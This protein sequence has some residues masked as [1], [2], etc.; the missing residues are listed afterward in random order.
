MSIYIST[1]NEDFVAMT[2]KACPVHPQGGTLRMVR[3]ERSVAIGFE[4]SEGSVVYVQDVQEF[5]DAVQDLA[6]M[7]DSPPPEPEPKPESTE[8]EPEEEPYAADNAE[9]A[10]AV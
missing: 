8:P 4:S 9:E 1:D 5:L 2:T 10:P 7:I 6:E 3:H